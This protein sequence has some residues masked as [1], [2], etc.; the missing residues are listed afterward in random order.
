VHVKLRE[1]ALHVRQREPHG[2]RIA[3]RRQRIDHRPA[4]IAESQQLCDFVE[5]LAGSIV[6]R[7]AEQAVQ[8]PFPHFVEMRVASADHQRERRIFNRVLTRH[9]MNM[10]LNMVHRD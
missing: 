7:L 10:P 1:L 6:A 4:R 2:L 5:G 8:E 3:V 9:R